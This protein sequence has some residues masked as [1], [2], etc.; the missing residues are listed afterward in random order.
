M[1]PRWTPT[2][3]TYSTIECFPA[4]STDL[5]VACSVDS[6]A[7][8]DLYER[9]SGPATRATRQ[10]VIIWSHAMQMSCSKAASIIKF[11]SSDNHSFDSFAPVGGFRPSPAARL[12]QWL[13]EVDMDTAG[14][15]PLGKELY[16]QLMNLRSGSEPRGTAVSFVHSPY[17]ARVH[18][19][20][21]CGD[22]VADSRSE[23][24]DLEDAFRNG[25]CRSE[26]S[27]AQRIT[28]LD[29]CLLLA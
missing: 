9:S 26:V 12:L 22:H 23:G 17:I 7:W 13:L 28:V 2:E 21:V 15:T 4:S 19:K 20:S 18:T 29:I 5:Q 10:V 3:S 25:T 24:T 8:A 11:C 6:C 27:D 16:K 14:R 1:L